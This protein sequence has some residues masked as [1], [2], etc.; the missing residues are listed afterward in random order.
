MGQPLNYLL[1]HDLE[2][3][4]VE[5][6]TDG[7]ITLPIIDEMLDVD[8]HGWTPVRDRA[9]GGRQYTPSSHATTLESKKSVWRIERGIHKEPGVYLA[10]RIARALHTSVDFLCGAY[11]TKDSEQLAAVAS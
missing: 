4:P 11:D 8:L 3:C 6:L 1:Q 5:K 7:L 9:M 10:G 2:K